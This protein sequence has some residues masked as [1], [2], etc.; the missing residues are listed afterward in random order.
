MLPL[1]VSSRRMLLDAELER[2]APTLTGIVADLG[3]RRARRGR[4]DAS[5]VPCRRWVRLNIDPLAHPDVVADVTALPLRDASVDSAVC[6]ETLQYV[7]VP[8]MALGEMRRVL[9]PAGRLVVSVPFLHRMDAPTDRH[10][11]TERRLRELVEGA[12]LEVLWIA[13]QGL[14]FTTLAHLIRQALAQIPARMLRYASA[15]VVLPL[16]AGFHRMDRVPV[17]RRSS[18][19][20][21]FT[22]GFVV[23][24]RRP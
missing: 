19:L 13:P 16:C 18:F 11:F 4:F 2:L 20:A 21:S 22:T 7:A 5:R 15:A 10:R 8:E 1:G 23:V 3:G 6:L 24:A 14:F 9:A 17:V 12:G